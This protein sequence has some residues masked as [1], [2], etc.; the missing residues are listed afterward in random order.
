MDKSFGIDDSYLFQK[1]KNRKLPKIPIHESTDMNRSNS[2]NSPITDNNQKD[3][4]QS[5]K[6]LN[7][8]PGRS[9]ALSRLISSSIKQRESRTLQKLNTSASLQKAKG[10]RLIPID[11][12]QKQI[13][14]LL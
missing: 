4:N 6:S 9:T 13:P 2:R 12:K 3:K 5:R 11:A 10:K 14:K 7:P 1:F 8:R